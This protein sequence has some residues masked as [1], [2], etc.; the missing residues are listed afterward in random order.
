MSKLH[1]DL[2]YRFGLLLFFFFCIL[3]SF[4]VILYTVHDI[5]KGVGGGV[6]GGVEE[7]WGGGSGEEE[8]GEGVG[9]GEEWGGGGRRSGEE[10]IVYVSKRRNLQPLQKKIHILINQLENRLVSICLNNQDP[11]LIHV[12]ILPRYLLLRKNGKK[13]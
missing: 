7:E 11:K 2:S 9:G 1:P 3:S 8:W 13:S 6:G 5:L 12:N 4:S 10:V